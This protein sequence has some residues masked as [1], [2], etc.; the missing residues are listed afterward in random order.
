[1]GHPSLPGF[2]APTAGR[3][4]DEPSRVISLRSF[5]LRKVRTLLQ[6]VT[7][8]IVDDNLGR[9]PERLTIKFA[10]LRADDF[11][12]FRGT[13]ALFYRTLEL[14]RALLASPAALACGDLHLQNFGSYKGDNRLVYFDL[15][16]FDESCVAPVAFELVR[17]LTS[18]LLAGDTLK[19]G[20]KV[21]T[22]LLKTFI[23][24]Y[25]AQLISQKP[26]WIERPLATG[27]V[28][29]LLR[30]L[31][32]RH[33]RD[34]IKLRTRRKLGKTRLIIDG[35]R[36]LAA[37]THDRAQAKAILAAY[38]RT[39][40]AE[41]FFEPI[42]IARRIAGNGSLG[43][44]RYTALVRG[45]GKVEG[46]YLVDIKRA[47]T[48]SL[49][50]HCGTRQPHWKHEAQR[51]ASIQG[52]MQA[53]SPALLG[54]VAHGAQSYL[55]KEMQPTADRVNLPALKGDAAT[56]QALIRTMA[57]VTAWGQLRGCA[58]HGAAPVEALADFAAQGKWRRQVTDSAHHAEQ[59]VQQ[60]WQTYASDYDA[61]LLGA[62]RKTI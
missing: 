8:A 23:D 19:L 20:K 42:D 61:G 15:N 2:A 29:T 49:A 39:Q 31:K 18:V 52:I 43:L 35:K 10:A 33:R 41:D 57:A 4:R 21:T 55:I 44:E 14:D 5:D 22:D 38:A 28:K 27:P 48:S 40:P 45:Y 46:Q 37:T 25:A 7:Q 9:D 51:V 16:D 60:Q 6:A 50:P 58:R 62:K 12:F 54:A 1:M 24:T 17:F 3:V 11:A 59:L 30:S 34:L 53:I 36:T 47:S 13:S 56:L 32:G 26:R